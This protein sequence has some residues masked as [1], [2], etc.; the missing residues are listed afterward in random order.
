MLEFWSDKGLRKAN[1]DSMTSIIITAYK[2]ESFVSQAIASVRRQTSQDWECVVVDDGSPDNTLHSAQSSAVDDSRIRVYTKPNGGPSSARNF[3]YRKA[4]THADFLVFLDGDDALGEEFVERLSGIL[5]SRSDAGM[6][7]CGFDEISLSGEFLRRG[8]RSRWA[9]GKLGWPRRL[10]EDELE[11]PF[12]AFFCAT[13]QGPFAMFRRRVFEL[14]NGWDESFWPHEDT[15]IACQMAL[16]AP[17]LYC[18]EALYVKRV[19]AGSIMQT[20]HEEASREFSA[21]RADAYGLFRAKWDQVQAKTPEERARLCFARTYY[22]RRHLTC[23]SVKVGIQATK[24]W[25]RNPTRGGCRWV[26]E[27]FCEAFMGVFGRRRGA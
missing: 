27:C 21:F 14:T 4:S 11:T 18:P 26:T 7:T 2:Q 23:R 10:K 19:H 8:L 15:D 13:G 22:A 16:I 24:E 5:N 17:V 6:I 20:N 3:G 12:E 1:S 25:L 9:C